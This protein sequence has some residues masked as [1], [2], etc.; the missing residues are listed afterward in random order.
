MYDPHSLNNQPGR[1]ISESDD[2]QP[3]PRVFRVPV[4]RVTLIHQNQGEKSPHDQ[5]DDLEGPGE[6]SSGNGGEGEV[7]QPSS[8]SESMAYGC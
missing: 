8:R 1:E 6:L 4:S 5:F 3:Q 7:R 2:G